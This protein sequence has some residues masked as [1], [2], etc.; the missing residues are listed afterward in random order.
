VKQ[1][2]WSLVFLL[3]AGWLL[4]PQ[5]V[6][7]LSSDDDTGNYVRR[8]PEDYNFLP[9]VLDPGKSTG[10]TGSLRDTVSYNMVYD[11]GYEVQCAKP[12]WDITPQVYGAIQEYFELYSTPVTL[13][14]SASYNVD[15]SQ[16][17]V[18][19]YRGDE[20]LS[21]TRKN[22]SFEGYFGATNL[23]DSPPELNSSGV[24][25]LLLNADG[26]CVA[27]YAN[28]KSLFGVDGGICSKL[29]DSGQCVLDREI[30]STATP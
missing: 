17:T 23:D 18:P 11:Q 13:S 28:L 24:A 26:Q 4:H 19:L 12:Q 25:N 30:A 7:A 3:F 14:G 6:V 21:D 29:A 20:D 5:S 10:N 2:L 22:S 9:L 8:D 15:F 16:G 27:K 1:A